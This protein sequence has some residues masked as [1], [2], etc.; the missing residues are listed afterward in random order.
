MLLT[1]TH[2]TNDIE[3]VNLNCTIATT[4]II[5]AKHMIVIESFCNE[6][7]HNVKED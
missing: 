3:L 5:N 2:R 6:V 1:F 7:A 4:R